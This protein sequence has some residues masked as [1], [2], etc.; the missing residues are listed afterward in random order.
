MRSLQHPADTKSKLVVGGDL[1]DD[2]T[3]YRTLLGALRYLTFT[4]PDIVYNVQQVCL[5]MHD[6]RAYT[7]MLSSVFCGTFKVR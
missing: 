2:P 1:V 6:L 4:H 3:L 7:F 5:F